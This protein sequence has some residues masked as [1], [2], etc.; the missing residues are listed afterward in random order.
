MSTLESGKE[1]IN[2]LWLTLLMLGN[3]FSGLAVFFLFSGSGFPDQPNYL[4]LVE[5]LMSYGEFSSYCNEIGCLPETL[6]TPGYPLFLLD[7]HW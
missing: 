1:K 4:A 3:F 7:D 6:R 5:G 2:L